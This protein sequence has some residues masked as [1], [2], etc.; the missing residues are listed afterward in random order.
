MKNAGIS[1]AIVQD[2]IGHESARISA[3]YTHIDDAAKRDALSAMPDVFAEQPF[4]TGAHQDESKR[5]PANH[6]I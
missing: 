4:G 6:S 1:A 5:K 3:S 2:I